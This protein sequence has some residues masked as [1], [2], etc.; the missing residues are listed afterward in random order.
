[1][2]VEVGKYYK[3]ATGEKVGPMKPDG[4]KSVTD[5]RSLRSWNRKSGERMVRNGGV[6]D[7]IA[8]LTETPL[9]PVRTK[10][11]AEIVPGLYSGVKVNDP[12]VNPATPNRVHVS[13]FG[14]LDATELRA[15]AL[16]L[17]QLAEALEE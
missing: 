8:E 11:V 5:G 7:L 13:M 9:G 2:I 1:M 12:G 4:L 10:T 6:D 3:T 15:A 14:Y 17:T 16:V